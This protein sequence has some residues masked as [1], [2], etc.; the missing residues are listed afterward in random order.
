MRTITPRKSLFTLIELLVVIAII[1]IL[2]AML[3]PALSK[4]REKAR[5]ISCVSNSKQLALAVNQYAMDYADTL[6][7]QVNGA[8]ANTAQNYSGLDNSGFSIKSRWY[9]AIFPFVGDQKAYLCPSTSHTNTQC[10]YG[11]PAGTVDGQLGMPYIMSGKHIPRAAL[12]AHITPSQTMYFACASTL[13][14]GAATGY[15]YAPSQGDGTDSYKNGRVNDL[16]NGGSNSGMLDGHVESY[17]IDKY[18]LA[19]TLNGSDAASRLWAHYE[20]GK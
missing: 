7:F 8:S 13:A 12:T 9:G 16:H 6:P 1:A 15:I 2:A 18:N 17:K 14:V 20:I 10:G 11:S 3:L 4:A 19:T 5:A